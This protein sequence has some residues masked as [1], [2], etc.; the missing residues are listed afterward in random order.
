MLERIIVWSCFAEENWTV[1]LAVL[2]CYNQCGQI[3]CIVFI[4]F[5]A[6]IC[7]KF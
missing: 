6:L 3:P 5:S 4:K 7:V 2:N 1:K